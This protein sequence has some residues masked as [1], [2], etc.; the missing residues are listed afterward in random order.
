MATGSQ[1]LGFSVLSRYQDRIMENMATVVTVLFFFYHIPYTSHHPHPKM[2]NEQPAHSTR[3]IMY[4]FSPLPTP[5]FLV[6]V[7]SIHQLFCSV[8][9]IFLFR[10]L[11]VS[12]IKTGLSH[13]WGGP[14]ESDQ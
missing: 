2:A 4:V 9:I 5:A 1:F 7:A 12:I 6:L 3:L 13:F 10:I 8:I 11:V 14:M